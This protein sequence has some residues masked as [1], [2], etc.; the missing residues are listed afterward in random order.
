MHSW[1]HIWIT[2]LA[3]SKSRPCFCCLA[4]LQTP[5]KTS[6]CGRTLLVV[7]GSGHT[8]EAKRRK[9]VCVG[10]CCLSV[11]LLV[12]SRPQEWRS[13]CALLWNI[14]KWLAFGRFWKYEPKRDCVVSASRLNGEEGKGRDGEGFEWE[15]KERK[16]RERKWITQYN[17]GQK[18]NERCMQRNRGSDLEG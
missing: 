1:I 13:Q 12:C 6:W 2:F 7:A 8:C 9:Y 17:S 14:L 15:G 3:F 4:Y 10:V 16:N 18:L 11:S 5:H